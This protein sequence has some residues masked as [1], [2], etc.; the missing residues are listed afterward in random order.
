METQP[1]V[2]APPVITHEHASG[3]VAAANSVEAARGMCP[4]L[5]K[6]SLEEAGLLLELEAMGKELLAEQEGQSKPKPESASK[7]IESATE[8][9]PQKVERTK[10]DDK[11]VLN[12]EPKQVHVAPAAVVTPAKESTDRSVDREAADRKLPVH[13]DL[14]S[15]LAEFDRCRRCR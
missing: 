4:V 2:E 9:K 8:P 14:Q 11:E 6:M 15:L 5:G 7:K 1:K 3:E 12:A 13:I 10:S